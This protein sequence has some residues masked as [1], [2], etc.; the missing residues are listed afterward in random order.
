MN[1]HDFSAF[2]RLDNMR[3]H[4]SRVNKVI[5]KRA[6]RMAVTSADFWKYQPAWLF[7]RCVEAVRAMHPNAPK[8]RQRK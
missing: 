3:K 4:A 5:A 8:K 6:I 1:S 7:R 2:E